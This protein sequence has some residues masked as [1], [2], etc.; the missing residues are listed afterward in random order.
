M[1][2]YTWFCRSIVISIHRDVHIAVCYQE[3]II[4]C[5]TRELWNTTRCHRST[6]VPPTPGCHSCEGTISVGAASLHWYHLFIHPPQ[7]RHLSV[8]SLSQAPIC[9]PHHSDVARLFTTPHWYQVFVHPIPVT[10][11]LFSPDP[12]HSFIRPNQ[13]S[14]T[15]LTTK[16]LSDIMTDNTAQI[17]NGPISLL[18]ITHQ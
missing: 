15:S 3:T 9:S 13:Q 1:C 12:R 7:W 2:V 11:A 18:T 17:N 6:Y 10:S 8:Y 16:T 14:T 4:V 5:P